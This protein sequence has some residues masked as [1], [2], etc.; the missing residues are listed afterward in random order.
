MLKA[1]S[2]NLIHLSLPEALCSN[3]AGFSQKHGKQKPAQTQEIS[4]ELYMR[5]RKWNRPRA[6]NI[7]D[8][9]HLSV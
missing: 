8:L 9:S 7:T 4:L 6:E 3:H 1:R 2:L 5:P